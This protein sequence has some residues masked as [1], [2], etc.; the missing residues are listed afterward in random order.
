[1]QPSQ[2][3]LGLLGRIPLATLVLVAGAILS[4]AAWRVVESQVE[5]EARA[6]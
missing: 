1:V 6:N 4:V 3:G 2:S 5:R